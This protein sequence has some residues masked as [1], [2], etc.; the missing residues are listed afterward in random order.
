MYGQ[1]KDD[2]AALL[3]VSFESENMT[4]PNSLTLDADKEMF[5]TATDQPERSEVRTAQGVPVA[6]RSPESPNPPG[7]MPKSFQGPGKPGKAISKKHLKVSTRF[8][9]QTSSS[10]LSS[11]AQ[12]KTQTKR[13]EVGETA[14]GT[15][16]PD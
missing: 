8:R 2:V 1:V 10:F 9:P 14:E 7:V 3:C 16:V 6:R 15:G 11:V 13:H 5:P 4:T 12:R